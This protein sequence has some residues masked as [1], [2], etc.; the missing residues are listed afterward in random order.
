MNP[1]D[2][3]CVGLI[4]FLKYRWTDRWATP[5]QLL[6]RLGKRWPVVCVEQPRYWRKPGPWVGAR[7]V[8]GVTVRFVES[9]MDIDVVVEG[10][11]DE[12]TV[13]RVVEDVKSKLEK[14][15]GEPCSATRIV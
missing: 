6:S 7:R 9:S 15:E 11:L 5:H 4:S 14:I 8:D 1:E 12:L 10:E 2:P 3:G 13:K